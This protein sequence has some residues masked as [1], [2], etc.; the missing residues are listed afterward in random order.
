MLSEVDAAPRLQEP[1]RT[2]PT[3]AGRA[4]R[5]AKRVNRLTA[6]LVGPAL[7]F[8]VWWLAAAS[9]IVSPTLLPGPVE[10]VSAIVDGITDGS[11]PADLLA[12]VTRMAGA[13]L[14][15][16][17]VGLPLG[18]LLGAS[19]A[20]YARFEFLID[21]FRST[22]V[23]ALF[24]LFLL[25]FGLGDAAK[26]AVAGFA[27]GLLVLFNV[28]YGVMSA[29]PTRKLAAK[30]MGASKGRILRTVTVYEA[31]PQTFV[32]LRTGVSLALVVIIVAEMF[33]GSDAGLGHRIINA[34]QTY[35]LADMYG[36]ILIAGVLG[37]AVNAVFLKLDTS[38]VHWAG[39]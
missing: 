4:R 6:P 7:L 3:A 21:F 31:L 10:S 27:A 29:R 36:S 18:I 8:G 1:A 12:T 33:I 19:Q 37:Y 13:L 17:V 25:I 24:P 34:Q 30:V 38:F 39:R 28:A 9:D 11:L 2:R 32:G 15:A 22:P 5:Y 14:I 35:D 20:V 23:T 16:V 26:I